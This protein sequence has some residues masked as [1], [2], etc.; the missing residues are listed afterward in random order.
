[1]DEGLLS[2]STVIVLREGEDERRGESCSR[3]RQEVHR[4]IIPVRAVD[5]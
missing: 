5:G 1:M 3:V 4:I 2:R